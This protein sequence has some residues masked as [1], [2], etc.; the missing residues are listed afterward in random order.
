MDVLD[1]FLREHA[2]VH[3]ACGGDFN[4]D[5]LVSDLSEA[6]WRARPHGLNSLA[7]TFWHLA[8]VEDGCLALIVAGEPQLLDA[9]RAAALRVD[10]PGDGEGMSKAE[11]AELSDGIDLD[12]LAAYRDDVG[13]RTRELARGLWPDRWSEPIAEADVARAAEAG[14]ATDD[15]SFVVGKPREM[16]LFWWGLHHSIYHLGQASMIKSALRAG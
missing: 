7:W 15:T 8:R 11:V 4:I 16:L 6:E 9:D 13:R 3:R 14:V 5:W 2:S 12:A 1:L 10:R